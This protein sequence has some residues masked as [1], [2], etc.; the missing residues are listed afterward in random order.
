VCHELDT[1]LSQAIED[2]GY[3][4][5]ENDKRSYCE[6][7]FKVTLFKVIF[8]IY[9]KIYNFIVMDQMSKSL[10]SEQ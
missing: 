9:I 5:S 7:L 8:R 2:S 4:K 1:D 6:D 3:K 10:T